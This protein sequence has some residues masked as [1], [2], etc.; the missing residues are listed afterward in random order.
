MY[1]VWNHSVFWTRTVHGAFP[2]DAAS[3]SRVGYPVQRNDLQP[4]DEVFFADRS[5]YVFHVGMY[6]GTGLFV[7]AANPAQGVRVD[8]LIVGY[9]ARSYAGARRYSLP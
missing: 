8:S 4:G 2:R 6:I 7:H 5:G 1:W 9:Y 3:Q